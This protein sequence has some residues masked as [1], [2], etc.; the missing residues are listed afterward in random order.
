MTESHSK[1]S[2]VSSPPPLPIEIR[3]P[4]SQPPSSIQ[5]DDNLAKEI[6]AMEVELSDINNL[7]Q[8]ELLS[9]KAG[10]VAMDSLILY[11][12]QQVIIMHEWG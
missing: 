8:V 3:S 10:I 1:G 11:Q 9:I 4:T 5:I 2:S 6:E 12:S 7:V